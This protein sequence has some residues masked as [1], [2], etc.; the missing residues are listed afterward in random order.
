L[1]CQAGSFTSSTGAHLCVL[2]ARGHT[3]NEDRTKQVPCGVGKFAADEGATECTACAP[4][5]FSTDAVTA[6]C[7]KCAVGYFQDQ[8]GQTYCSA[9]NG[10]GYSDEEGLASCKACSLFSFSEED[11]PVTQ[12]T[13]CFILK[14]MYGFKQWKQCLY[15]PAA[16]MAAVFGMFA[17]CCC[18]GVA[19]VKKT[20]DASLE[21]DKGDAAE[22]S[23][24]MDPEAPLLADAD[25]RSSSD[26]A[27]AEGG[28]PLATAASVAWASVQNPEQTHQPRPNACAENDS[29]D[30]PSAAERE[31]LDHLEAARLLGLDER[32]GAVQP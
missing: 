11:G 18:C 15:Y 31:A 17:F 29:K 8:S 3:T 24:A 10:G 14:N 12:C 4:G 25:D 2:A 19:V 26:K 20:R 16:A 30:E 23:N 9:C 6:Q 22:A 27:A 32:D 21:T 13:A 1:Q 5:T 28:I 7:E